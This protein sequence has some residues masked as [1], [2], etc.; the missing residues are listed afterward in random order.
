M[1]TRTDALISSSIYATGAIGGTSLVS[2]TNY[3]WL[4]AF[5]AVA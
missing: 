4:L 5:P 2:T 3:L 1:T